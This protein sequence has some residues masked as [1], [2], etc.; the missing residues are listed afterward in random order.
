MKTANKI[1]SIIL[2]VAMIFSS[3]A[4]ILSANAEAYAGGPAGENATWTIDSDGT[5][6]ISGTGKVE[7]DYCNPPWQA[8]DDRIVKIVIEEGLTEIASGVFY[9]ALNCI[10]ISIPSTVSHI[11]NYAFPYADSLERFEVAEDNA[12]YK[13]VDGVIYSKDGKSLCHFPDNKKLTEFTV[14]SGVETIESY[15]FYNNKSLKK[16]IVSD[17]VK[18]IGHSAFT[19]SEV[20]EVVLGNGVTEIQYSAFSQSKIE[21][22]VI[23]DSVESLGTG[24]CWDAYYLKNLV[25]GSGVKSIA[26]TMLKYTSNLKTVH[27]TGT[28]A[29]WDAIAI[30]A[31]NADLK[32]KDLHFVAEGEGYAPTC[33]EGQGAGLY[34]EICDEYFSGEAI[35]AVYPHSFNSESVCDECGYVRKVDVEFCIDNNPGMRK[36]NYGHTLMLYADVT[37]KPDGAQV[38]WYV[39]GELVCKSQNF[40]F[41]YESGTKYVT[42]VLVDEMGNVYLDANGNELSDSQVVTIKTGFFQKLILFFKNLFGISCVVVQNINVIR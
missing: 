31:D 25:I 16:I 10:S 41:N 33:K 40:E 29:E 15:A 22:L 26:S 37:D 14:P 23:P 30:N 34:C 8:Y 1:L 9:R 18:V 5:L 3:S 42:A 20:P 38:Y 32:S 12:T 11:H 36:I 19:Y 17:T 24:L 35:P 28:Q 2:V 4:L 13:S 21:S 39:D 7:V 6:T 27:Y